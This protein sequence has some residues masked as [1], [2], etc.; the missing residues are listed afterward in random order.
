MALDAKE[1]LRALERD[2]GR[3]LPS[4]PAAANGLI[5]VGIENRLAA[6]D[7]VTGSARWS[8][9]TGDGVGSTP[10]VHD[11]QRVCRLQRS[12]RLRLRRRFRDAE[13]ERATSDRVYTSAPV[14]VGTDVYVGLS[15]G[16]GTCSTRRQPR[17]ALELPDRRRGDSTRAV[18]GGVVFVGSLDGTFYAVDAATGSALV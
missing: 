15:T 16:S 2:G 4:A 8:G 17:G 11:G 3:Q 12:Q 13:V 10:T 7:A 5:Y 9:A 14:A 18:A 6:I 1:R